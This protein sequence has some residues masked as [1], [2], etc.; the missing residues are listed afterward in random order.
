MTTPMPTT[1]APAATPAATPVTTSSTPETTPVPT[2]KPTPK[3]TQVGVAQTVTGT[4]LLGMG[5]DS[6]VVVSLTA[7]VGGAVTATVLGAG[8]EQ[9]LQVVSA[10]GTS[11]D[12]PIASMN[13]SQVVKVSS[14][15]AS[16]VIATS[17]LPLGSDAIA[18]S[19]ALGLAIQPPFDVDLEMKVTGLRRGFGEK[20]VDHLTE[21]RR[22]VS[23]RLGYRRQL[24]TTF[25]MHWLS[26]GKNKWVYLCQDHTED[27]AKGTVSTK[28][29]KETLEDDDFNPNAESGT[30]HCHKDLVCDG[31][32]GILMVMKLDAAPLCVLEKTTGI[33]V[34]VGVAGFLLVVIAIVFYFLYKRVN[35]VKKTL[36]QTPRSYQGAE[37]QPLNP[38][39]NQPAYAQLPGNLSEEYQAVDSGMDIEEAADQAAEQADLPPRRKP[40]QMDL[41]Q[42]LAQ[43]IV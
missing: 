9:K 11:I 25:A 15:A 23:A 26:K 10:S 37:M 8:A 2:P 32:G 39:S 14:Q 35:R 29:K 36:N 1:P 12:I 42:K 38:S 13:A 20:L 33:A 21:L 7:G 18:V 16:T 28:I 4:E 5:T 6:A 27:A 41:E 24:P 40:T 19:E 17:A 31:S 3:P 22:G 43:G 34:A 30:K